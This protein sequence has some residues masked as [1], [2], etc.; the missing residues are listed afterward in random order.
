MIHLVEQYA[1][2]RIHAGEPCYSL[3]NRQQEGILGRVGAYDVDVLMLVQ[4]LV[5][6]SAMAPSCDRYCAFG[7]SNKY[8]TLRQGK[9]YCHY[10]RRSKNEC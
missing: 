2:N 4:L 10:L 3:H 5:P 9:I 8:L 7:I 1:Q 6:A